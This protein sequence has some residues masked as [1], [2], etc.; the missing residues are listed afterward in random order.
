M[1]IEMMK[2]EDVEQVSRLDNICFPTPWSMSAY[3]TEVHNPSGYYIV[4]KE[5]DRVI[6][7]AGEW[8]IMDEAHITTIG[9]DPEF[10]R[11]GC[12]EWMLIILLEEAIKRGAN[13]AIL[14]VRRYNGAAQ[15]L[16]RKYGFEPM[17]IRKG[18]YTNNKEDA[19]VMWLN[20]M[21]SPAFKETL[22]RNKETLES[23]YDSIGN[24]EQL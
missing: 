5:A 21:A 14:E 4:A 8:V 12:A 10:R 1:H 15:N 9:V 16:Y 7:F 13:R 20:D 6:G 22:A 24:R 3:I 2:L 19:I 11:R 18:Y 23:K 17:A